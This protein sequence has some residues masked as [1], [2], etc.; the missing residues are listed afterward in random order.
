MKQVRLENIDNCHK[1][2]FKKEKKKLKQR[3]SD[4][5]VVEIWTQNPYFQ[6]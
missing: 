5:K 1:K 3:I 6:A 4:L 2:K